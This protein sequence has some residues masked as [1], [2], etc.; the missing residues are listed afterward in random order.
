MMYVYEVFERVWFCDHIYF[1]FHGTFSS[2]SEARKHAMRV[3]SRESGRNRF[4]FVKEWTIPEIDLDS[5]SEIKTCIKQVGQDEYSFG[6]WT[7]YIFQKEV[8]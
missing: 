4:H 6:A 8:R 1:E 5:N 3:A 7:I 2:R